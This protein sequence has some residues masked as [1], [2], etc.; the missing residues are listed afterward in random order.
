MRIE[1]RT[2]DNFFGENPD[3]RASAASNRDALVVSG[4]SPT[5]YRCF[6]VRTR[7]VRVPA[8][9]VLIAPHMT[10][11]IDSP[12]VASPSDQRVTFVELFFDL[13]FVFCVTQVVRLL[14]DGV[15]TRSVGEVVLVFWMVWWAWTQF[16]WAL[17]AAD[18]THPR[19][20]I[21]TLLTTAVAFFMA[22][23]IPSAFHGHAMWFAGTYVAVRVL[24]LLVYDWVAWTDPSQRQAVR[25]FSV[26]SIG[27]MVA[28]LSGAFLGGAAQYALWALAIFL[29][30]IAATVGGRSEGWNLHAEHFSERHGLFVI[31]ALGESVIVAALSLSDGE[32]PIEQV[33]MAILA[34]A[35]A[36]A[37]WWS[38]FARC[39][40]ELDH[41]LESAEGVERSMLA[42]DAYSIIHFPMVLGIIAFAA[43][44]EHGLAHPD[45][46]FGFSGRALLAVSVLLFAGGMGLALARAGR[47][48]AMTRRWLP[49]VTA[50]AVFALAGVQ[51][52][53]SLAVVL[54]GLTLMVFG[55]PVRIR[56]HLKARHASTSE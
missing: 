50:S 28:V 46:P 27:G 47:P 4:F 7:V 36:C 37:M 19:V 24:G 5:Q 6:S 45:D 3:T 15:T 22:V 43:T 29:D 23:G 20:Q 54:I 14:H 31:I 12:Q 32:W 34:V 52:L 13:V 17:N 55:E 1:Q 10:A 39:K 42:R 56:H 21:A 38:Y 51:A 11:Q 44:V 48:V 26:V 8:L 16:T 33:A 53:V 30:L 41:S 25:R 40:V 49:V 9:P 2:T 35:I 18:T